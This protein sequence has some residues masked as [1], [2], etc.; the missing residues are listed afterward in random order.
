VAE[1]DRDSESFFGHYDSAT[2]DGLLSGAA[3]IRFSA[4]SE[5]EAALAAVDPD[6]SGFRL[7]SDLRDLTR[8]E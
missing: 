6:R 4:G 2:P 3:R 5:A 1:G 8:G 7:T